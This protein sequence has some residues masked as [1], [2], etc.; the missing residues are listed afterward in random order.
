MAHSTP[1]SADEI[2]PDWINEI[3][4]K[5]GDLNG[6]R[7]SDFDISVLGDGVG[8]LGDLCRLVPAYETNADQYPS[9]LVVKF[10]TEYEGGKDIGRNL[11]AY[12]REVQFYA[13][14]A[15]GAPWCNPPKHYYS[16]TTT[17]GLHDVWLYQRCW[18]HRPT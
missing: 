5:E 10:P 13:N 14:C 8:F 9:S 18:Q 16:T 15:N 7:A 17:C 4:F 1:G 11:G 3:L 12:E 2:T 6:A